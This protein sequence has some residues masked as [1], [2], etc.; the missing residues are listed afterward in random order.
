MCGIV[1]MLGLDES[2]ADKAVIERMT[3]SL[4]HR[5]PDGGGIRMAGRVGFG[6]RRLAILDLSPA[7]DQPMASDDGQFILV[8]NGEIYNY[9]E[10]RRELESLGHK[11]KSTGDTEVLLQAYR[12]WG[13]ECV[14]KFNGMWAFIIYDRQRGRLFGSRDRFGIKPLYLYRAANCFLFAS[15]IKAILCSGLYRPSP[16]WEVVA[17]FLLK[18]RLDDSAES[19][20]QGVEQIGR[21]H[22]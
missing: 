6:F 20:Y 4:W 3:A 11:F 13:R 12:Q 1:A 22:V 14:H 9:I 10:L 2:P 18:D 5:G 21:A 15:E 16:N 7:A 17:N 19:F 8:F